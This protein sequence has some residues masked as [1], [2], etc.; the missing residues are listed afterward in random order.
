MDLPPLR[1][2]RAF[3]VDPYGR[4]LW[5]LSLLALFVATRQVSP[6]PMAPDA[7]QGSLVPLPESIRSLLVTARRRLTLAAVGPA[8][9]DGGGCGGMPRRRFRRG[10]GGDPAVGRGGAL[11]ALA[12]AWWW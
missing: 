5:P 12:V 6:H 3:G 9:D 2:R 4:H 7:L 10:S 11:P 8:A 1:P